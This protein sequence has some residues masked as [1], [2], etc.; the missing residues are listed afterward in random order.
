MDTTADMANEVG[1]FRAERALHVQ[2]I[3]RRK[4]DGD[5]FLRIRLL[6]ELVPGTDVGAFL[7]LLPLVYEYVGGDCSPEGAARLGISLEDARSS[8]VARL[9]EALGVRP[10][11]GADASGEQVSYA[12]VADQLQE[13]L[14]AA[15]PSVPPSLRPLLQAGWD[16]PA[17]AGVAASRLAHERDNGD[18]GRA[19][20]GAMR[21]RLRRRPATTAPPTLA[22]PCGMCE[23]SYATKVQFEAHIDRIHAGMARYRESLIGLYTCSPHITTPQEHRSAIESFAFCYQYGVKQRQD[24]QPPRRCFQGCAFCAMQHWPEEQHQVYLVTP[25]IPVCDSSATRPAKCFMPSPGLVADLLCV[26]KYK[27][28]W[29][30]I[31]AEE[32]DASAVDLPHLAPDGTPTS[33]K[34][35]MHRKRVSKA[36]LEGKET[37]AICQCC[38]DAYSKRNPRAMSK[39]ALS[40]NLWLGR[41]PP[42][43]R[44]ASLG[45]QLLLA[46]ARVVSTKV[47]L[48][49]KGV[50]ESARQHASTWRRRFLQS[51]IQGTAIV[52]N[53]ASATEAL[54]GF[55]PTAEELQQ[56]FAAVFTGPENPT[57]A[58]Q[59]DIEGSG[60]E[61]AK[62]RETMA[63]ARM[64]KEV[65]LEVDKVLLDEQARFLLRTNYA[66]KSDGNYRSDLVAAL[67]SGKAVPPCFEACAAFVKVDAAD[68]DMKQASGPASS[69]TAGELE[70]EAR[71]AEELVKW[72]SVID[73][74]TSDA[75]EMSVLPTIQRLLER[76]ESQAGRVAVNE[77]NSVLSDGGTGPQDRLGRKRLKD[78]CRD[79]HVL[80]DKFSPEEEAQALLW[81]VQAL[82]TNSLRPAGAEPP[83]HQDDSRPDGPGVRAQLRVPTLRQPLSWWSPTYW[84]SAR[85][86]EFCYGDCV[87]GLEGDGPPL[88]VAD[89]IQVLL[90]REELEYTLPGEQE[91]YRAA[92]VNRF[93]LSWPVLHI[94]HS[95]WRVTETTKS[96]HTFL[97]TPGAFGIASGIVDLTPE[98]LEEYNAGERARRQESIYAEA[99][100]RQGRTGD[101][102]EGAEFPA[103]GNCTLGRLE[104]TPTAGP[105]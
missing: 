31:P 42:L 34:V 102:E 79:F 23:A 60:P 99:S 77:L 93:R 6:S 62:A 44:D 7:H 94:L 45:H 98:M 49:S 96:I 1:Q 81:R 75:A 88:D 100:S 24:G 46:L 3:K 86:T 17:E 36:A 52:F 53:N 19:G 33:T 91:T 103:S 2:N 70:E 15:L 83:A 4:A 82:A 84:P 61:H 76:M 18:H 90:R 27:S 57:E 30:D 9:E 8:G 51:G 39:T 95:F 69:T 63:R 32:L 48:S 68:S 12:Q 38:F 85:P 80:C 13:L 74:D 29:P 40:N 66:Y 37:V 97:K 104:R 55:P 35:L 16:A 5:M 89:W 64:R 21:F 92:P 78:I 72:M 43:L 25:E 22:F 73:E 71:D 56:T 26:E 59:E 20:Y 50:D 58:Q 105:A 87:W 47:Y 11:S 101:S 14:L 54:A 41:H 10:S 28:A 65:E 67:P